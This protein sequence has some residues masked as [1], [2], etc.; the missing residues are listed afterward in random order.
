MRPMEEML[1]RDVAQLKSYPSFE[2]VAEKC[3]RQM[4][5]SGVLDKLARQPGVAALNIES[6]AFLFDDAAELIQELMVIAAK[7][8]GEL[9]IPVSVSCDVT[10]MQVEEA[11]KFGMVDEQPEEKKKEEDEC[12]S[13][14]SADRRNKLLN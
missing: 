7:A 5:R 8:Y 12:Q 1:K 2:D 9:G 10:Q 13:K 3:T 11:G 6:V 4:V 14:A